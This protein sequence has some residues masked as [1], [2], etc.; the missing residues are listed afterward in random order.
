[1]SEKI[2]IETRK[3][4]SPDKLKKGLECCGNSCDCKKCPYYRKSRCEE[5]DRDALAYIRQLE[6]ELEAVKRERDAAVRW[7]IGNCNVC[8]WAGTE[9]CDSCDEH[10]DPWYDDSNSNWEWEGVC[11]ENT[12]VREDAAK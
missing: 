10:E 3:V 4:E 1:M 2:M 7:L 12:E 5:K 11:P 9:K 6:A 8:R